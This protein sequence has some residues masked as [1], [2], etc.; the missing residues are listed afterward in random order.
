[1]NAA[2]FLARDN[3]IIETA[4]DVLTPDDVTLLQ[5]A[6]SAIASLRGLGYRIV[7]ITNTPEVA[8][9]KVKEQGVEQVHQ[10]IS[11]LVRQTSGGVIDRFYFCPYDPGARTKGLKRDHPWRLPKPGMLEQAA[12]DMQIDLTQSWTIGAAP[13]VVEAGAAAKTRTIFLQPDVT[14]HDEPAMPA[15]STPYFKARTLVE[16]IRIVAQQLRPDSVETIRDKP[17]LLRRPAQAE[18]GNGDKPSTPPPT[19]PPA[20]Q[21]PAAIAL[22]QPTKAPPPAPAPKP[23]PPSPPAPTNA[24]A[25]SPAA[26][27]DP[28]PTAD[29]N[30]KRPSA[31]STLDATLKQI[32]QE[33]RNQR[34]GGIE[35]SFVRIIAI[36]VQLLAVFAVIVAMILG[37]DDMAT[38]IAWLCGAI[39]LQLGTIALLL[40]DRH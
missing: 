29:D 17:S 38:L 3:T 6:A 7:V 4:D 5:G 8:A 9:G 11:E 28:A 25:P 20:P 40:F 34:D 24:P 10:R 27:P 31:P 15:I 30:A 23:A 1:M 13:Q 36:I 22:D 16:A 35:F 37:A 12:E 21:P 19:S 14:D 26:R 39:F 18:A 33:L 32:L 2:V